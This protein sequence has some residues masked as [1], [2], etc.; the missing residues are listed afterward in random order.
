MSEFPAAPVAVQNSIVTSSDL[1]SNGYDNECLLQGGCKIFLRRALHVGLLYFEG[2]RLSPVLGRSP[3]GAAEEA[4]HYKAQS[5]KARRQLKRLLLPR[6]ERSSNPIL[7]CVLEVAVAHKDLPTSRRIQLRCH[8]C[9]STPS[10]HT[11]VRSIDDE[12]DT[13]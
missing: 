10:V 13:G 1:Y 6:Q 7:G 4:R 3:C 11:D 8:C 2:R 12:R 5:L 9:A